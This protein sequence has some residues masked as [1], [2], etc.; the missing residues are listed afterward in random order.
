MPAANENRVAIR[1]L[2][3]TDDFRFRT[4]QATLCNQAPSTKT[5][6]STCDK[7]SFTRIAAD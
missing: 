2:K 1:F 6:R 4:N 7:L 3:K 5:E